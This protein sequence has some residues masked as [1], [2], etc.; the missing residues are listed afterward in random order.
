MRDFFFGLFGLAVLLGLGA[1]I[2]QHN[3][4]PWVRYQR[5][6]YAQK[7]KLL[8]E[9]KNKARDVRETERLDR[10]IE[11]IRAT[12]P[13]VQQI[14]LSHLNWADRCTTC[15]LGIEDPQ[16]SNAPQPFR[17][18]PEPFLSWHPPEQF[19]CTPCHRGQGLATT[20]D[21]HGG[22]RNWKEPMLP[23]EFL[24][25]SC[26]TCH[27]NLTKR[28]APIWFRGREL[29]DFLG[30]RGCHAIGGLKSAEK[31]GPPLNNES[32]KVKPGWLLN[33]LKDP[34]KYSAETRMPNYKL[35]EA[36]TLALRDFLMTLRTDPDPAEAVRWD[37]GEKQAARGKKLFED[38]GC[39]SCHALAAA[40]PAGFF[41]A[42]K[43][44]P[45]LSRI[46]E[47]INPVWLVNYLMDPSRVQP[48]TRMPLYRLTR[49]QAQDL[50]AF[51][52]SQ[53]AENS[54]DQD[55]EPAFQP[56]PARAREGKGLAIK[57][58]CVG[59][60]EIEGIRQGEA[61]PPLD[62]IGGRNVERLDFGSNPKGKDRSLYSWLEAKLTTPR[63]YREGLKMPEVNLR[64]GEEKAVVT[65]L[66]SLVARPFPE[67]HP[68]GTRVAAPHTLEPAV[69]S[70]GPAG[71]LWRKLQCTSCHRIG[72]SGG[73]IGPDLS[74]EGSRVRRAWLEQYLKRPKPL[75]PLLQARMPDFHL[76]DS[77]VRI[78]ADFISTSLWS[79][80]VGRNSRGSLDLSRETAEKGRLL[81]RES[82]CIG[83]H[84]LEGKGGKVGPRLDRIAERLN[85]D[86]I[87][88]YLKDPQRMFRG[89]A[90]TP[91]Y[92][93]DDEQIRA[94]TAYLLRGVP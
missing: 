48:G 29:V 16:F 51:L 85:E 60:H 13:Q 4:R 63:T 53:N 17:T 23:A 42:P 31:I 28:V 93:F 78:L 91:N 50:A 34:R 9:A 72:N 37:P 22:A 40:K 27:R 35:P 39:L 57:Y 80:D 79:Q 24:E 7:E 86:W 61:G 19:G 82:G 90:M 26:A 49:D 3:Q 11:K 33:Y 25:A 38:L 6:F 84:E 71:T 45:E 15:H 81:L 68:E 75:R 83:C 20:R 55:G 54:K 77:E 10:E 21:A 47:K 66:L 62:G 56:D 74:G 36:E 70:G 8:I 32:R 59:C 89:A 12:S 18:H 67:L 87:R 92:G 1:V 30:C 69:P 41:Q 46:R 64:R 76:Q 44:G 65:F 52:L 5:E 88:A 14:A 94:L 73:S 58:N 2:W 43:P